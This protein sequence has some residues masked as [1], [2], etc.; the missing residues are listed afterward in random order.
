[1]HKGTNPRSELSYTVESAR[2]SAS[3]D[4]TAL[5]SSS[6]E[7]DLEAFER[8]VVRH[9]KRML[10]VAY[11]LTDDYD[12]ACEIVQDAFVSA[13]RNIKT[14]RGDA[15]FTTWLTT[16]TLNLSKNR[17]KQMRA[18]RGHEAFSLDEQV[19]TDDG[20]M[21]IDPPSKEPSVLDRLEA[22]DVRARVRDCIKA[23]EPDFREALVLRDLQDFS[24]EEIGGMLK[25]KAGTVKSRISRARELVKECLKKVMEEM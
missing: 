12:E 22:R 13:F 23:L 4:D 5:V 9:Q 1:M 24:Y 17:L 3:D 11:R 10:N 19:A 8:L 25:V 6:Q 20:R 18:R 2:A 16:I 14:F 15:K 21:T 7:G